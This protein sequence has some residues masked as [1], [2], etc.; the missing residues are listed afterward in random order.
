[1]YNYNYFFPPYSQLTFY[2]DKPGR[3]TIHFGLAGQ[4]SNHVDI[5]VMRTYK[6]H[7]CYN[8][9][10]TAMVITHTRTGAASIKTLEDS[11][12]DERG[13]ESGEGQGGGGGR[14]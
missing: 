14:R 8:P 9:L 6:P 13:I 10:S 12:K 11:E 3:H 1:M 2:A 7:S 5:D 4:P